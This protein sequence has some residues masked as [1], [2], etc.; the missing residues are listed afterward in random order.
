MKYIKERVQ[1]VVK[2]TPGTGAIHYLRVQKTN[3]QHP[4]QQ[5]PTD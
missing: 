3:R 2:I 4:W 1:G 5:E